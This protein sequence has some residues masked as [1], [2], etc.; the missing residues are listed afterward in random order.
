MGSITYSW[1]QSDEAPEA[2]TFVTLLNRRGDSLGTGRVLASRDTGEAEAAERSKRSAG[3]E[4]LPR[5][6][7][8]TV[9]DVEVPSH[10]MWEARGIRIP[11]AHASA[12]DPDF[13]DLSEREFFAERV[14]IS[15]NG[16]RR[17][18]RNGI[19]ISTA[20]FE[21]G[22]QR[23]NDR[24]L[25]EDGSCGL[26][27]VSVD[28][29]RQLA[30]QTRVRKGMAIKSVREEIS[31]DDL[32]PC[33]GIAESEFRDRVEQGSLRSVDATLETTGLGSGKCHGQL[34]LGPAKRCLE[35]AGLDTAEV[36]SHVDWR[37]PWSD[38]KVDPG[39]LK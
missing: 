23:A 11:K 16:E 12:A 3:D 38:W 22:F 20:F 5:L 39:K 4:P 7:S 21:N 18:V 8:E 28:G 17:F 15:W 1:R 27:E 26:C 9:V 35:R 36:R 29:I 37:F 19:P 24:L 31:S 14:E 33:L 30:C 32:C 13:V 10:L 2:G 34:C 25:C 6:F